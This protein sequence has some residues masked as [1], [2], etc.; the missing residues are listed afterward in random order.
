MKVNLKRINLNDRRRLKGAILLLRGHDR[1]VARI[2]KMY[3]LPKDANP[4]I[5]T[6]E[7]SFQ[8]KL[9]KMMKKTKY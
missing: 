9:M 5:V 7:Q 8:K 4:A 1:R 3:N 6:E 2:E